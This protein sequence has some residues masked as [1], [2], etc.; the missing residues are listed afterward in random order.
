MREG[1]REGGRGKERE[2][3]AGEWREGKETREGAR[4]GWRR[5]SGREG[6]GAAHDCWPC[7]APTSMQNMMNAR[8][9]GIARSHISLWTSSGTIGDGVGVRVRV[10]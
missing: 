8:P 2:G 1:G 10:E 5:A 3:R 7:T 6:G 9:I 4:E